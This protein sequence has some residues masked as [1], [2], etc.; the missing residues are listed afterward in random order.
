MATGREKEWAGQGEAGQASIGQGKAGRT[1]PVMHCRFRW[2]E[3]SCTVVRSSLKTM[4]L[5]PRSSQNK[6]RC[7]TAASLFG[8]MIHRDLRCRALESR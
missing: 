7:S 8:F 1:A 4:I 6:T 5:C 3:Y 2:Y